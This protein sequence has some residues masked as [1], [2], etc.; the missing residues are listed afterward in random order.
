[1]GKLY[2]L[3]IIIPP[4]LFLAIWLNHVYVQWKED[5]VFWKQVDAMIEKREQEYLKNIKRAL[6]KTTPIIVDFI[7]KNQK[8]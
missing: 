4:A 8:Q 2:L 1:M 7:K 5:R 3:L 6:E